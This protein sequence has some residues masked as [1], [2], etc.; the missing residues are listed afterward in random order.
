[1]ALLRQ[2]GDFT[3]VFAS[4]PPGAR[5]SASQEKLRRLPG[6]WHS[7]AKSLE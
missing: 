4:A 7:Q 1:M 3:K 2:F 5:G 6:T